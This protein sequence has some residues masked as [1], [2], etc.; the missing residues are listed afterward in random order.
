MRVD[1][2][3]WKNGWN[4]VEIALT[5]GEIDILIE[6]LNMLKN[7]PDQHFH[8]SSDYKT[9]GGI[10]DIEVYVKQPDQVE[11]MWLGGKALLP[12]EEI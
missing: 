6:R 7:D 5:L 8:I 11:N 4:G 12:G 1:L 9:A 3:D 10:G 2:K